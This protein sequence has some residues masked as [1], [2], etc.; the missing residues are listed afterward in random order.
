MPET[1][2]PHDGADRRDGIVC[3]VSQRG[4]GRASRLDVADRIEKKLPSR[5]ISMFIHK[6]SSKIQGDVNWS[7]YAEVYDLMAANNPAYQH[8]VAAMRTAISS[9]CLK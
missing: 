2:P 1:E 4:G 7:A 8:L 9:W 3:P 6:A 5:R